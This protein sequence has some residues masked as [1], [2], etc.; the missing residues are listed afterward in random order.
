[1]D[2]EKEEA[3]FNLGIGDIPVEGFFITN[4]TLENFVVEGFP[5]ELQN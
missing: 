1:L 2:F 4:F 5:S 3:Y